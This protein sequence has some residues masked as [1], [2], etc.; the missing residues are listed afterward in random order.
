[1]QSTIVGLIVLFWVVSFFVKQISPFS[2]LFIFS[3]V[4]Y[5]QFIASNIID[6]VLKTLFLLSLLVYGIKGKIKYKICLCL[7]I[8]ALL[9]YFSSMTHVVLGFSYTIVDSITAFVSFVIGLIIFCLKISKREALNIL[10]TIMLL[11][12][13]SLLVGIP[14]YLMGLTEYTSRAGT[15]I[16]GASLETNLSFFAVVGI[17]SAL[18]LKLDSK[19]ALYTI[20]EIVNFIIVCGTLTRGGIIAAL[21][22]VFPDVVHFIRFN[23]LKVKGIVFSIVFLI[24]VPIP[25]FVLLEKIISRTFSD[26]VINT[27]GRFDAWNYIISLVSNKIFGNGYGFLKTMDNDPRLVA[28]TAAHNEYVRAYFETG[29]IGI[30]LL[31]LIFL[32]IYLYLKKSVIMDIRY[33]VLFSGLSFLTYAFTDNCITNYRFWIPFMF[34]YGCWMIFRK[35]D[36]IIENTERFV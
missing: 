26:G 8:S 18:I 21:I 2:V 32:V 19:K 12:S 9:I 17:M 1:M 27:S 11:P 4:Y 14:T 5:Q 33:Y 28:F 35:G 23:L 16:A 30:S 36:R 10:H 34:T 31:I 20:F 22:M 25:A 29:V 6:T 7:L 13:I 24:I 3:V 15:A